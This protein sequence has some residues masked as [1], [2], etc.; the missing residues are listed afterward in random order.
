MC[1]CG[2]MSVWSIG[3]RLLGW[4]STVPTSM[5]AVSMVHC[6]PWMKPSITTPWHYC[7]RFPH[8]TLRY[9]RTPTPYYP[10]LE[11]NNRI[12][13]FTKPTVGEEKKIPIVLR[14]LYICMWPGPEWLILT[15]WRFPTGRSYRILY[16]AQGHAST[17]R[18]ST[19][20]LVVQIY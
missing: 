3:F 9:S 18:E 8:R 19:V 10:D 17:I 5:R 4:K 15:F 13:T 1:W 14:M 20:H 11:T 6:S 12:N 7:C 16:G 2:A